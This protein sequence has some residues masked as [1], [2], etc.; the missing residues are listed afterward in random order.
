MARYLIPKPINR[1]RELLPGWGFQQILV[2]LVAAA[3]GGALFALLSILGW[4]PGLVR[5]LVGIA[6]AGL[7][8]ALAITP[9]QGQPAYRL[10]HAALQYRKSH[11]RYLFDWNAPDWPK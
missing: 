4:L 5:L 9:P 10:I 7:G 8:V 1:D 11:R 3:I 2:I 6:S